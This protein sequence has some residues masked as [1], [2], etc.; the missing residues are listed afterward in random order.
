M[1]DEVA[2]TRSR[3]A[4]HDYS[5]KTDKN[6]EMLLQYFETKTWIDQNKCKKN[7]ISRPSSRLL[8]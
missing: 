2:S 6:V 4:A 5:S 3:A 7:K 1:S 8:W